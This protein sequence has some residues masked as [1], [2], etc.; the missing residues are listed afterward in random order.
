MD[1]TNSVQF[2]HP[3]VLFPFNLLPAQFIPL[4]LFHTPL[5]CFCPLTT[6]WLRN[7]CSGSQT[8]RETGPLG[9]SL[10]DWSQR[11]FF[12][13]AQVI[14]KTSTEWLITVRKGR[15]HSTR[16]QRRTEEIP[17]RLAGALKWEEQV[18]GGGRQHGWAKGPS[19]ECQ[20]TSQKR[21]RTRERTEFLK[22]K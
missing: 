5:R 21:A 22:L 13:Q 19:V 11:L 10:Q 9:S 12:C 7:R 15:P 14:L 6:R 17:R 8:G 3:V 18:T 4:L 20:L 2:A 16:R 1:L